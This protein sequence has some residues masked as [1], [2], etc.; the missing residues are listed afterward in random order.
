M[1]FLDIYNLQAA[2]EQKEGRK[3]TEV[4]LN[5]TDMDEM[6]RRL[7][8]N[9]KTFPATILDNN[10]WDGMPRQAWYSDGTVPIGTA[11]FI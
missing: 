9:S 8:T 2:W 11:V 6:S 10:I 3:A 5:P 4:R 7:F 1:E